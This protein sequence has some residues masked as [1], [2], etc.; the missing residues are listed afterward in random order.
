MEREDFSWGYPEMLGFLY[1][2]SKTAGKIIN[3]YNELAEEQ[4][5]EE[6]SEEEASDGD[7][8]A[9]PTGGT[10]LSAPS[11]EALEFYRHS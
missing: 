6:N 3:H 1:S 10:P 9:P 7:S 4:E 8:D 11:E 2:F 5:L